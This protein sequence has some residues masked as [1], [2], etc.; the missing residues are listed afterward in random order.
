MSGD[1]ASGHAA[2]GHWAGAGLEHAKGYA[3]A[4]GFPRVSGEHLVGA[5][6]K[7]Y[8]A[9]PDLLAAVNVALACEMPLL[10]TG[11]PG[12]GKT[13]FA[14][15]VAGE[16]RRGRAGAEFD[17]LD[18]AVRSDSRSR[19]LLYHYDAVRRF[20]DA[21]LRAVA[22]SA[23][24]REPD[25]PAR[26]VTLQGLG[27]ALSSEHQ[28][29]VLIDEID[30]APRDLPNDLLRPLEKWTF[31]VPEISED[32][33]LFV[34]GQELRAHMGPPS[35]GALPLV[36]ITSNVER[37]LPEP[38]LRRCVFHHIQFPPEP[39]LLEILASHHGGSPGDL[40]Y[41]R[42][43]RIFGKLRD[44]PTHLSKAPSTSELLSWA[45]VLLTVYERRF[46][47]EVIAAFV[48]ALDEAEARNAPV[49]ALPWSRLPGLPCVVKLR[50]DLERLGVLGR[51]AEAP[52]R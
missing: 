1:S 25:H 35:P 5:L 26:Y 47:D 18:C 10:L 39:A 40:F 44:V 31:D 52:A 19:D 45:R 29:V 43:V 27:R 3:R 2:S 50:E 48:G 49:G 36:I 16:L 7:R 32:S 4:H 11:E 22:T 9:H 17:L 38:F 42:V 24:G 51:A 23:V 21:Q 37:Q 14:W 33:P 34:R 12:C 30:K 41:R 28:R 46:V 20:G 6:G 15:A 8:F 13:D